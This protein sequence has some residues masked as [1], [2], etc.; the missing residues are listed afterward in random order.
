M[1]Y[2]IQGG[3]IPHLCRLQRITVDDDAVRVVV[4]SRRSGW[5]ESLGLVCHNQSLHEP[6]WAVSDI[7]ME[8]EETLATPTSY[9]DRVFAEPD[10]DGTR[11]RL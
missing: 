4:L 2:A 7:C 6:S 9:T 10:E 8:L 5:T 11:W 3:I 1:V